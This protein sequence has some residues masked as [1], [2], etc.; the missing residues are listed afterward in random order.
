MH[1]ALHQLSK[2][3]V[4]D[5]WDITS[6]TAATER[7]DKAQL[8]YTTPDINPPV[9]PFINK[10][11]MHICITCPSSPVPSSLRS[12]HFNC[13]PASQETV[14]LKDCQTLQLR[15]AVVSEC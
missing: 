5:K 6:A 10:K 11:D 14:T 12:F 7:G 8:G 4:R 13:H 1:K 3:T 2:E 9:F 15:A